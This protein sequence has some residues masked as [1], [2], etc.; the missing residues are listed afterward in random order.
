MDT[1]LTV[2]SAEEW[3]GIT[4]DEAVPPI[5]TATWKQDLADVHL[6]VLDS[7]DVLQARCSLWWTAVPPHPSY[8]LGVI[9][10][11]AARTDDVA[12]TLLREAF[13]LLK[14]N[15]CDYAVGPMNGSTWKSYRFVTDPGTEPPFFLEP[16]NPAE[17][18][19]QFV[20]AGFNVFAE[21]TSALS[22]SAMVGDG[23]I[24]KMGRRL[25]AIGVTTRPLDKDRLE[26]EIRAIY[27]ASLTI[28]QDNLLYSPISEEDFLDMYRP[29]LPMVQS[30][31]ILLAERE[32][33]L[34]GYV[35]GIPDVLQGLNGQ[36]VDTLII[37]TLARLPG[38]DYV[39]LGAVLA[40]RCE[41]IAS[42]QFGCHR[43]I[44][45]LMHVN[46][47]SLAISK[48]FAKTIRRYTLFGMEIS[49]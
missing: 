42:E 15:G 16:V 37:K 11:Y 18:P 24:D 8:R 13:R 40:Q 49:S 2:T 19:H 36:K 3:K 48:R 30:D 29:V 9:G 7:R 41:A 34:V 25:E 47:A 20:R 26:D 39:G 21:Y 32:G 17:Y 4:F 38:P 14:D 23:R 35:F 31:T 33:E 46:N 45:A 1:V 10:H 5:E 6:M 28:F 22:P 12:A 44:H 43:I 27:R